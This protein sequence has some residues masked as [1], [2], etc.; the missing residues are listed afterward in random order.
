MSDK[1][2]ARPERERWHKSTMPWMKKCQEWIQI[3]QPLKGTVREYWEQLWGSPVG[4]VVKN[5]P[6]MQ[7]TWIYSPGQEDPQE[8]DMATH[9]S[10]LA[11][12]VPGTEEPGRL[13][14]T[15]SHRIGQDWPTEHPHSTW[16]TLCLYV[17]QFK[18]NRPICWLITET[19]HLTKYF[20]HWWW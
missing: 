7:E 12:E 15:G 6:A 9:S 20:T 16:T 10:I 11:W 1:P 18:R 13:Q 8:K 19:R 3:L 5:L 17:Q 2:L 14:S 4:S